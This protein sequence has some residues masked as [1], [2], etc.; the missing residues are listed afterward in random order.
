[1]CPNT[2]SLEMQLQTG[3]YLLTLRAWGRN[4]IKYW[5]RLWK[6]LANVLLKSV[7]KAVCTEDHPLMQSVQYIAGIQWFWRPLPP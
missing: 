5:Q 7:Y 3:R 6:A 4:K 1:M 2:S